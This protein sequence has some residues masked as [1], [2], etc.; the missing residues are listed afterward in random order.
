MKRNYEDPIYKDWRMKVKRR[1][2][3]TC[4]MPNCGSKKRLHAHHITKW[5]SASSLRYETNNGITL[6]YPCHKQVT[7]HEN[8]YENLFK[9][10]VR[11]KNV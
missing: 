2:G 9:E 6:C 4:Q 11:H 5:A 8:I 3:F 7:G 10:I 1:D